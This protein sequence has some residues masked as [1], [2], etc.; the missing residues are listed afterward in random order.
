MNNEGVFKYV[1]ISGAYD[2]L[3]TVLSQSAGN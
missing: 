2:T 1:Y 3:K